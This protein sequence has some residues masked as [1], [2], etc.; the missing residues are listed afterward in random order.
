VD[1]YNVIHAWPVLKRTLQDS[2]L[3]HARRTL[4]HE[5]SEY[6][7]QLG[8]D[9]TVVFD[10]H[11]KGGMQTEQMDG[12]TV[13]YGSALASADHVIERLAYEAARNGRAEHVVVATSDRLQRAMVT[14]M[15]VATMG[16]TALL[17]EV[18]RVSAE[19]QQTGTRLR[20]VADS[21]RRVQDG[22]SDE[23]R[24]RLEQIRRDYGTSDQEAAPS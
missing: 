6:S 8:V 14:A 3:E 20:S 12:V 23:T 22:L 1:G 11:R 4:V 9:V 18:T 10:S 19:R 16:A 24:N 2:G 15:G 17:E 13:H 7:A 21:A 5:L